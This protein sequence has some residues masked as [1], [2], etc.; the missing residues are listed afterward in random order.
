M[1]YK[2]RDK[3]KIVDSGKIYTSYEEAAVMLRL[4][5][6]VKYRYSFDDISG[7]V[8]EVVNVIQHPRDNKILVGI[9]FSEKSTYKDYIVGE[10]GLMLIESAP[11]ISLPQEL[12]E[13]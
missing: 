6:F 7:R 12:F 1:N 13:I 5:Y 11:V 2:I 3:V 8:A 4:S 10:E 9:R